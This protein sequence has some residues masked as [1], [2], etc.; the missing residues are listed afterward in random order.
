VSS[1]AAAERVA[2]AFFGAVVKPRSVLVV[3]LGQAGFMLKTSSGKVL[4]IDPYLSNDAAASHGLKRVS[5]APITTALVSPDL[6]CVTHPHVD[7][8]DPATIRAYGNRGT[9]TLVAAPT[10]IEIA[11]AELG[12]TGPVISLAA[13]ESSEVTGLRVT[14]TWTRHGSCEEAPGPDEAVGFLLEID[15]IRLWHPGDTEY[16]ATLHRAAPGRIDVGFLPI[17]GSGGNMNA[18]EAALLAWQ[19]RVGVVIPMHFGMWS[20]QAYSYGGSEPWATPRPDEFIDTYAR[21]SPDATVIVPQPGEPI[22]LDRDQGSEREHDSGQN[23][24]GEG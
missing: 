22:V 16:D 12:W 18:H 13:G 23:A 8:L 3:W 15:E 7:H 14:A 20:E 5:P 4:M 17:N 6:L 10:T 11:R 24:T 1:L 19:L 2:E 21:L 9:V